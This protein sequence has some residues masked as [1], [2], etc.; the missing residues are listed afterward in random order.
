M[1]NIVS[2]VNSYPEARQRAGASAKMIM[3]ILVN[4]SLLFAVALSLAAQDIDQTGPLAGHSSH[5]EAFNEGPRQ[6]AYLISGTGKI[7]FKVTTQSR[8]AQKFFEQGVGQL[9]GFWYFEAERSFRQAAALDPDCAMNYWGMAMANLKNKE[10]RLGFIE[11]AVKRKEAVSKKEAMWIEA[12]AA[13][14]ADDKKKDKDKRGD[15]VKALEAMVKAFPEDLEP[16]AFL[17][18]Q[19]W[20][21][22]SKG[23]PIKDYSKVENL[24]NEVLAAEP[25]HPCHHYRIHLWDYKDA[26]KALNSAARAGQASPGIAHMWHMP[27]H[28]FSRLKRYRDAIWQQEASA[29]VDHAHMMRD[30]VMP[31]QIHN[32]AHNNEWMI[33]NLNFVGRAHDAIALAKNM[34]EL[35]Q[36]PKYN[37][38]SKRGS[39]NY[40]RNRLMDTLVN[41]ELWPQLISLSDTVYLS[42]IDNEDDTIKR[43][44]LLGLAYFDQGRFDEARAQI[45][46]LE[47]LLAKREKARDKAVEEAV[48]KAEKEKKSKKD[49]DKAKGK[50]RGAARRKVDAVSNALAELRIHDALSRG[51]KAAA[52]KLASKIG[53]AP[54]IR[55]A[56]IHLALDDKKKASELA[57]KAIE[58]TDNQVLPLAN[59]ADILFQ[60]EDYENACRKFL[61]LRKISSGID[62][63]LDV[64]QRLRPIADD[65]G[66]GYDWRI[67]AEKRDDVGKRPML[68]SLGPV[69]WEPSPAPKWEL[70]DVNGNEIA[71]KDYAGKPAL[72]IFYLG[73]G[74]LH[75]IQQL[76][77]FAPVTKDF[78]AAGI[79]LVAISLD[80]A[81]GLNKSLTTSGIEGGY[82]FPL[83]SDRSMKV[84]K[85]YRAFDDFEN[86]PLHGTFLIDG[87]GLIRWQDISYQP[88]EDT[89][90]LLKESKRLLSQTKAPILAKERDVRTFL[91]AR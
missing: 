74:C 35:P 60:L 85:D 67:K 68:A 73:D 65:L 56:R 84:F 7:D 62:L 82:P 24:L 70:P 32:F 43:T 14:L 66:L 72:L 11:E 83:L 81:E 6:A 89:A 69:H 46:P 71:L 15:L 20:D 2:I 36:H 39:A 37:T 52:K 80:T 79:S 54:K 88:F 9:H 87:E 8:K 91:S 30:G 31:D 55:Q 27:G 38:S 44:H 1:V 13:Y 77:A 53:S 47:A 41:Y 5:G 51:D 78:E 58:K 3:K 28:I 21:N 48:K 50:A 64:F 90:F 18:L 4:L 76:K 16:K 63:D 86:M 25:M 17:A 10:R 59:C 42:P 61:A 29:R 34:T 26:A 57:N 75:C 19:Y 22:R 49:I 23:W 45:P 12:F 40:G 33:R